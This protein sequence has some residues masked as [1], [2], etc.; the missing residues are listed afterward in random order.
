MGVGR[1]AVLIMLA[2]AGPMTM[3]ASAPASAEE[4]YKSVDQAGKVTY[5]ATPPADAVTMETVES[6]RQPTPEE[7]CAAQEL[8]Q[9]IKSVGAELEQDRKQ[10]KR[11]QARIEAE[12][13]ARQIA[14]P[15]VI[16]FLP[17][18]VFFG[19]I[20]PLPPL[21]HPPSPTRPHERPMSR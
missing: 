9:I 19:P 7:V 15:L 4:I 16:V 21:N 17:V 14:S 20:R 6:P 11:E 13:R 3:G 18:P 1:S 2:I 12:E 8:H 10:R 5:S